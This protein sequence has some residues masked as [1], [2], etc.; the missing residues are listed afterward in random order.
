MPLRTSA[1]SF[2]PQIAVRHVKCTTLHKCENAVRRNEKASNNQS[3]KTPPPTTL[4]KKLLKSL[5]VLSL[6]K[7][8]SNH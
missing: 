5:E 3:K 7:N 1:K 4:S 6:R 2:Q 8:E